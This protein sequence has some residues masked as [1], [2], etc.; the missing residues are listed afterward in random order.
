[1]SRK[2][3]S[4]IDEIL[5]ALTGYQLQRATSVAM[6]RYKSVF[7]SFGLRRTT[8]SCLSLIVGNPGL[9]QGQLAAALAIERSNIVQVVEDLT[10]S[11][12]IV[13]EPSKADRR[14]YALKPTN[15]GIELQ[16][17]ALKAAQALDKQITRGLSP[18]D[19]KILEAALRLVEENTGLSDP[20]SEKDAVSDPEQTPH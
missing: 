4:S 14:A 16:Q 3:C 12:L 10:R 1:M 6:V 8:F 19:L 17:K 15:E 11:G 9:Q 13:R 20:E 5:R 2:S 7:A 18:D